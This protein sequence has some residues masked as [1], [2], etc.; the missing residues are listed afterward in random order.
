MVG[1]KVW[2]NGQNITMTHPIKKLDHKWLALPFKKVVSR[3][4]LQ[5]Q[6]TLFLQQVHPVFLVTLLRPY[7]VDAITKH[8]QQV[9][10]TPPI[11]HDGVEVY[12][13]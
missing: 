12:K 10:P 7:D 8:V 2:L 9:P 6:A 4:N 5:A 13:V 11:V 1:D 3:N